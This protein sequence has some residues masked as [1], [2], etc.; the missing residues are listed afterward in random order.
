M[1]RCLPPLA[2]KTLGKPRLA[3]DGS[4]CGMQ[5]AFGGVWN[6]VGAASG[7]FRTLRSA[8]RDPA[9][10]EKAGETFN[11]RFALFLGG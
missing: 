4:L 3:L 7:E 6:F 11:M 10:F 1:K 9:A 5:D 2:A 8:A